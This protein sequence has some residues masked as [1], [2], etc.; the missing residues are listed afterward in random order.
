[1][2]FQSIALP[3]E[4]YHQPNLVAQIYQL[5]SKLKQKFQFI[6]TYIIFTLMKAENHVLVI[7][8]G[9][10]SIKVGSF[11]NRHLKTVKIFT[12]KNLHFFEKWLSTQVKYDAI[13]SSVLSNEDTEKIIALLENYLL[14]SAETEL[15]ITLDYKTKHTLGID[16]ICNAVYSAAN[17]STDYGVTID[18]GTC[19]KFDL[20]GPNKHYIGGSISPGI[21]LRYKSL[22][23]Y[24]GKLPLI[25]TKSKATLIGNDTNSCIHSGV[26]NGL[27]AEITLMMAE[28]RVQFPSLTFFMTGGDAS[29]FDLVSKNDIFADENLT[30]KGLHEIYKHNA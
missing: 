11:I 17:S 21:Q 8:A 6:F 29:H 25:S 12:I 15:P 3:T 20:T 13:V 30:L 19:V 22:N 23:D 10:T 14:V 7:D 2:D 26:M 28:Y 4:L 24:T 1:M 27:K 9:N 18:I 5:F 16:R